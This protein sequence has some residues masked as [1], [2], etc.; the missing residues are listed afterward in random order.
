MVPAPVLMA[1]VVLLQIRYGLAKT[2]T[3]TATAGCNTRALQTKPELLPHDPSGMKHRRP[4]KQ[5]APSVKTAGNV[6]LN[7]M[8]KAR[9]PRTPCSE[10]GKQKATASAAAMRSARIATPL[11]H[12][13]AR[14]R[15]K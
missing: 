8:E 5:P 14:T 13:L 7:R 4:H 10:D 12:F 11:V 15:P 6:L 3:A 2:E 9:G 1:H